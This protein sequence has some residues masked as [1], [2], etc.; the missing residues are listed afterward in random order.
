MTTTL[1]TATPVDVDWPETAPALR[2]NPVRRLVRGRAADPSWVRPSLLA[3]LAATGLL[4][5]WDLAASGWANAFYSAAV[6]AGS[7]NWEAFFYGSSDAGNSIT[8]DKPPAS[9]WI[10]EL[11][12]RLF[13][14]SSWS[15]LVPEALM[16]VATV[17]VLY[18]AV[19]RVAGPAVGL[20]AGAVLALTP[21]AVLMFRFDNPDAL[22]TLLMTLAAYALVRA[23]EKAS[24]RW[25]LGVGALVGLAFLTKTLQAMLVVPGLGLAYLVAAPTTLRTRLGHLLAAGAA[26]VLVGGWWVAILELVPASARP[27]IGGSQHNS[28][29]ELIWGYNG[30]GRLT[31]NETGS[32]G[33]GGFGGAGGQWGAT[34]L[35]RLFGS[36][37]GGQI[38]WLLP[39]ALVL[40]VGGLVA[41][42]RAART[43]VRRAALIAWGGWL[44]VTG[45]TFS[46]MA[47]IFHAYYTVALAP[48]IAALVGI[49]AGLLWQR[50]S[51]LWA[52]T[53]LG[54]ALIVTAT[55]SFVL[56]GRSASFLPDLRWLVLVSGILAAAGLVAVDRL[57]RGIA[58]AVVAVGVLAALGGPAAY[59]VDTA[60]TPHTGS[61]PSAG[62]T[63]AGA[64]GFGRGGF[65]GGGPG[66]FR[67]TGGPGAFGGPPPGGFG[68]PG[69]LPTGT[70]T[71]GT[72]GGFG[73]FG[74]G[75]R[76][77][78]GGLLD[79]ANVGSQVAAALAKDASSYTWVAAA[80]GSN[81]AAGYQLATQLPVM[82][83]GGFNGSDPSPTLA[84]F[85][86]YVQQGRIHWFIAGGGAGRM[87]GQGGS[88]A[89][90]RI[91]SWVESH[92]TARTIGGVTMYD[93]T[94][95]TS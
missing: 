16:G 80:V 51:A 6:Q 94:Q 90:A 3:L 35:T 73:G 79:A 74:G 57:A 30:L 10:M 28:V 15:I 77:G 78:M 69:T 9:L 42:G 44:V 18:L 52:R 82:P 59:A 91:T 84:R 83:I 62:P 68:G 4:Y 21:V 23:V 60:T 81:G 22:L 65:P 25:L 32:V 61:I 24:L 85:E 88:N 19:R 27:Y 89:A 38:S 11:S 5:L 50:R 1:P 45:L 93:L 34:G 63:V 41:V 95:P 17:G 29:W 39:A 37:I 71:A 48:A 87:R 92:F 49:G 12:V 46:L 67:G 66:G 8:V 40:L 20:F 54:V 14:L 75:A 7:S 33:G 43:D 26:M 53:V 76:G 72:P 86:Q 31:G 70:G 58:A 55:W 64:G 2:P 36:E 47:G 13:G 56:L